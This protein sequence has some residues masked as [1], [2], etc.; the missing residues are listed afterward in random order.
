M[1]VR[2]DLHENVDGLIDRAVDIVLGIWEVALAERS[3]HDRGVVAVGREHALRM[4]LVRIADHREQRFRLP[5]A[6]DDPV[7]V[8]DFVA[9]V[10]GVRLR[11]HHE[12]DIGGI[13]PECREVLHQVVD[14]IVRQRET[15]LGVRS[16][17]C[18]ATGG[19]R[20]GAQGTCLFLDEEPRRIAALEQRRLGHAIEQRRREPRGVF[21]RDLAGGFNSPDD[22]AFDAS[23]GIE[24]AHVRNVGGLARPGRD[25]AEARYHR[26][27]ERRMFAGFRALLRRRILART[28]SQQSLEQRKFTRVERAL[29]IGEVDE[30]RRDG[31]DTG[32]DGFERGTQFCDAKI[33]DCGGAEELNHGGRAFYRM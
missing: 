12:L 10:L 14:F 22:A 7:G 4:L 29:N 19:Q 30:T 32:M 20:H 5:L 24:T 27:L 15:Q 18:I 11:E 21:A 31:A 6:V 13:A 16:H 8:E 2:L 17:Q 28:V 33:G 3:F 26:D 1:V 25:R 23:H 9:A